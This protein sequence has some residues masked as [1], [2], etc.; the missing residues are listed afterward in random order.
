MWSNPQRSLLDLIAGPRET[1][2]IEQR[3]FNAMTAAVLFLGLIGV[4]AS[5]WFAPNPVLAS[6]AILPLAALGGA[7]LLSRLRGI[8]KPLIIPTIALMLLCDIVVWL[9]AG[10]SSGPAPVYAIALLAITIM[11]TRVHSGIIVSLFSVLVFG[12]FAVERFSPHWITEFDS[13][14][15]QSGAVVLAIL[16]SGLLL[17]MT[18]RA[19][20]SAYGEQEHLSTRLLKDLRESETSLHQANAFKT[21]LIGMAAHDI[22]NPLTGVLVTAELLQMDAVSLSEQ[23]ELVDTIMG[24][25]NRV[26]EIVERILDSEATQHGEIRVIPEMIELPTVLFEAA[27]RWRAAAA[28]KGISLEVAT[29]IARP[30]STDPRLLQQVLDN[31]LSNAIKFCSHGDTIAIQGW[32][33]ETEAVISV[34][35]SGP[36]IS[37][38]DCKDLF[39][40]YRRGSNHPTAKEHSSGLGLSIVQRL[41]TALGGGIVVESHVGVGTTFRVKLTPDGAN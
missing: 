23:H 2:T 10:G 20:I 17:V 32:G 36:G 14:A 16:L 21:E 25:T 9:S 31:L 8:Y 39:K 30:F 27:H 1:L 7:Y 18:L 35:D 28:E 13:P 33:T 41:V 5:S 26:I 12:L 15:Q 29:V 37:E 40:P 34:V 19:L 11:I 4:P 22:K 6:I 24:E 3:L 38:A